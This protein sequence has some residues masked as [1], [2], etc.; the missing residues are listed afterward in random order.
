[1]SSTSKSTIRIGGQRW[2]LLEALLDGE[3]IS[4]IEAFNRFGIMR[5]AAVVHYLREKLQVQIITI[6]KKE[7]YSNGKVVHYATYR[8]VTIFLLHER[9]RFGL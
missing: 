6:M 4:P 3:T 9:K 5:L 8:I 2:L 1:M 7:V